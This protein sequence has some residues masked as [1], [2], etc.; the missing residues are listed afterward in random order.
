[1]NFGACCCD[2][3]G[4]SGS[5]STRAFVTQG[6]WFVDSVNGNDSNNGATSTTA[7]RTLGELARRWNGATFSPA[8]TTVQVNLAGTFPTEYL[9]LDNA[10]FTAPGGTVVTVQATMQAIVNGT[11]TAIQAWDGTVAG[12]D[13]QRGRI[14]DAAQNF[15]TSVTNR[16]RLTASTTP[17]NVEALSHVASLGG[18]V[19]LANTGQFSSTAFGTVNPTVNDTYIVETYITAI[20][21]W[22]FNLQGEFSLVVRDI[23][24]LSAAVGSRSASNVEAQQ[25]VRFFGC[26]FNSSSGQQFNIEGKQQFISCSFI[27]NV[28]IFSIG[29]NFV[30]NCVFFGF[31]L[32]NGSQISFTACLFEGGGARN[33]ALFINNGS[34][35]E[36]TGGSGNFAFAFYGVLNGTG[37]ALITLEDFSVAILSNGAGNF[38]GATGNTTTDALIVRN[39]CGLSYVTKPKANGVAAGTDVVISGAAAIAWAGVPALAAAPNN[40]YVNVR[41]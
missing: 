36:A 15:T 6:A 26:E 3:S 33:A 38:I 4:T 12:A 14:T 27:G 22:S 30:Q 34:Y 31:T 13:G 10:V 37:A 32:I 18:G 11:V 5:L 23:R 16:I 17:A 2:C 19:T 9:M 8:L 1:M 29:Q 39:G 40:G 41:Q 25:R 21:G 28:N 35:V 7:L 24:F 20:Q